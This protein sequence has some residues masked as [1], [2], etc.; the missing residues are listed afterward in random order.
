MEILLIIL[1]ALLVIEGLPY[2]AFPKKA[3]LWALMLQEVPEPTLRK[4]GLLCVVAG[5]ALLWVTR[6]F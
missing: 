4:M 6:F 5:L 2:F 3:K 1:G